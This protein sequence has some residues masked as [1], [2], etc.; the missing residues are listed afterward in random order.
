MQQPAIRRTAVR[1]N[2]AVTGYP[3]R[4]ESAP[5]TAGGDS[6]WR[7]L[8]S[9]YF[10][11]GL[12]YIVVTGVSVIM[13]KRLGLSNTDI[14]LYTSWFYLP[15]ILKPFWSPLVDLLKT[16]RYWIVAMQFCVGAALGGIALTVPTDHSLQYTLLLFWLLA[17]SSA[18]HDIAADGFYMLALSKHDQAW[19]VGV[20]NTFF[21][22]AMISGQGLLV[23]VAGYLESASFLGN[24]VPLAWSYTFL[25]ACAVF[26]LLAAFHGRSLPRPG[27]DTAGRRLTPSTLLP[28][29][30]ET[31]VSFFR[32]KHIGVILAFLL[33][34]R[35]SEAQLVKISAPFL[36][37]PRAAGGLALSTTE[38]GV[39]TGV[40]GVVMLLIGGLAGGFLAARNGLRYWLLW[41]VA[42]INVPNAVYALLA[43][44]LPS[45][46]AVVNVAVAVEQFGY[47]FGFTAF[48]LYMLYVADGPH[49][50]AHFAICTGFMALGMMIPG[51]FSGWLQEMIGYR[52]F[53]V[54][55]LA[56]TIPSFIVT[57]L[58]PLDA[59]FGKP[60]SDIEEPEP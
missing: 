21:R 8:P 35:F 6:H 36:L 3:A 7:W 18:T 58:I 31:F 24:S 44:T 19:F 41:M 47:G 5:R 39:A 30:I 4:H 17:F 56:A 42:A 28:E 59:D 20:R 57:R 25:M 49:R 13:Y 10:A 15:W 54:W 23:V 60:A 26:L 51:M 48:T 53:F 2:N 46:F 43:Y 11:Q 27:K 9:L 12:P 1:A 29:F 55:I 50:T 52:Y 40:T 33:L 22:L 38:V 45:S 34:Y 32:K 14:A 37:D 16:R